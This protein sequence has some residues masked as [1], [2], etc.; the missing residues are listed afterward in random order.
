MG[1]DRS[2]DL[3]LRVYPGADADLTLYEDEG[4]N[5]AYE[6]GTRSTIAFHWSER[7]RTLSI[8]ERQGSFPGMTKKRQLTVHLAGSSA[9]TDRHLEYTGKKVT[10]AIN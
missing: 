2:G 6:T 5:Y 4:V 7:L 10:V 9:S 3:E 1:Q 8:G